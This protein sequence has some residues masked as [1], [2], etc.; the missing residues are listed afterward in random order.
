MRGDKGLAGPNCIMLKRRKLLFF[1]KEDGFK[2]AVWVG[3]EKKDEIIDC[4]CAV[5]G[6]CLWNEQEYTQLFR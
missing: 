3:E 6:V 1:K 4:I 2:Q 5:R